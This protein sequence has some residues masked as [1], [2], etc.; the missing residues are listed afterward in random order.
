MSIEARAAIKFL[1]A[2]FADTDP[3]FAT[4]QLLVEAEKYQDAL[5]QTADPRS[6]FE[7]GHS[8]GEGYVWFKV[9]CLLAVTYATHPDYRVEWQPRW[10]DEVTAP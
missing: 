2:R 7:V 6:E 9:L 5:N 3:G 4:R 10:L 1:W 8:T